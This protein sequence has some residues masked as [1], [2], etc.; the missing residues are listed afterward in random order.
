MAILGNTT[1]NGS[2]TAAGAIK[3]SGFMPLSDNVFSMGAASV[4]WANVY[5]VNVSASTVSAAFVGN[6][7]GTA[8]NASSVNNKAESALSVS[9]AANA[10][11]LGGKAEANLS[12]S[13]AANAGAALTATTASYLSGYSVSTTDN[14]H[15]PTWGYVP[16]VK[17]DGVIELGRYVDFHYNSA[18]AIDYAVRI[19][20]PHN[21]GIHIDLPSSSGTF[22]IANNSAQSG[23]ALNSHTHSYDLTSTTFVT[24][25]L[26]L[27][28]GGTGS[29]TAS[30][31]RTN[32]GLGTIAVESADSYVMKTSSAQTITGDVTI[33]GA[34]NVAGTVTQTSVS[35]IVISDKVVT[36]AKD[37]NAALASMV[38]VRVPLYD[39]TTDG[40]LGYDS[41]G[42]AFVGD[43]SAG[44]DD[45][46]ITSTI[47]TLKPLAVRATTGWDAQT[48]PVWDVATSGFIAGVSLSALE[49]NRSIFIRD[50]IGADTSVEGNF[51]AAAF[52]IQ[53]GDNVAMSTSAKGIIKISSSFR[54]IQAGGVDM[55]SLYGMS[56]V[57]YGA[58]SV[59]GVAGTT[60]STINT[61]TISHSAYTSRANINSS[62]SV[63][64][65]GHVTGGT[66]TNYALASSL[67][68]AAYMASTDFVRVSSFTNGVLT[69]I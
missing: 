40:F 22:A 53:A 59:I 32:L 30:E 41:T 34:L 58:V 49:S 24:G 69:L 4:R 67:G 63:D 47:A 35:N 66:F 12:V 1:V 29:A 37:N 50:S 33:A 51:D 39:G 2:L 64:A 62:I 25:I 26:P 45:S 46:A 65:Y 21:S 6:L 7:T 15:G 13:Y 61:V 9:Y 28:K 14:K 68:T 54:P 60:G 3:S 19:Y 36:L 48:V 5:A 52:I 20:A 27:A 44:I 56:V 18:E 17:G 42:T 31:A 57:G 43:I 8:S 23:Y 38:G 55:S 10:A 16:V 11:S